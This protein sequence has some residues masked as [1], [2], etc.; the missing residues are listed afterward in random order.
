MIDLNDILEIPE[1]KDALI[2]LMQKCIDAVDVEVMA[3]EIQDALGQTIYEWIET[4]IREDL[5]DQASKILAE[6]INSMV[7][8]MPLKFEFGNRNGGGE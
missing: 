5:L 1:T 3:K 8:E 2:K 7:A 6:R 4:T